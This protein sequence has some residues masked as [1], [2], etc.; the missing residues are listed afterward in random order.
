MGKMFL[1]VHADYL[2]V[3]LFQTLSDSLTVITAF[4]QEPP[5]SLLKIILF[6]FLASS[7]L[8]STIIV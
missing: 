5:L 1:P 2:C 3:S 6:Q 7:S 4:Q 8:N